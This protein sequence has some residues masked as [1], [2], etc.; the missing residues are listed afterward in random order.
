MTRML[1]LAF[2]A[3]AFSGTTIAQPNNR[4]DSAFAEGNA[5]Y[6]AGNHQEAL[7]AY[8]SI[9]ATHR[10]FASEFNA[11]NCAYKMGNL[12]LARLHYER[13]K[14]IEPKN[15][16]L[17]A[18]L[19]LL[20]AKIVDRIEAVP[21]LRLGTWL[22]AWVG[23]GMLRS[24]G[25]W[26]ILWWTIGWAL[27]MW[28]TR[29]ASRDSKS[30][31]AFLAAGCMGLGMV[32]MFGV[33]QSLAVTQTPDQVVVMSPR[34]NVVSTPSASGTVLFQLHEGVCAGIV[35]RTDD[36]VEIE[37]DNGNV[38]WIANAAVEEV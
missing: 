14:L 25:C 28:R 37:L 27:L 5:L 24:W 19:T 12:G 7:E 18:N 15:K 9:L 17:A 4:L 23:P 11:G 36:W 30:T 16:D 22:S 32:G 13:A 8:S 6:E 2:L 26:A 29:R 1:S 38:G 33:Q 20:E 35:S 3:L 31:L 34:E 21:S 10:H